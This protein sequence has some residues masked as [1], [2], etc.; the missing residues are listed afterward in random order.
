MNV[1][2]IAPNHHVL[3]E[4]DTDEGSDLQVCVK[5]DGGPV[6]AYIVDAPNR[7]AFEAGQEFEFFGP[8]DEKP[9]AE[10]VIAEDLDPDDGPWFL[11]VSNEGSSAVAAGTEI[12]VDD[13]EGEEEEEEEEPVSGGEGSEPEEEGEETSNGEAE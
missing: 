1:Y 13:E 11:I 3:E 7:A 5:T 8:D 6:F 2:L 10:H 9:A 12:L 4:L